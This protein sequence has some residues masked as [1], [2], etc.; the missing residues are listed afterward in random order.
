MS[1]RL[2]PGFVWNPLKLAMA[3]LGLRT[4]PTR[5]GHVAE[6]LEV[7]SAVDAKRIEIYLKD[8]IYAPL[9]G[10]EAVAK[11]AGVPLKLG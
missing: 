10:L 3:V 8:G 6:F 9:E 7:I 4:R 1:Y 5:A 2:K 11:R